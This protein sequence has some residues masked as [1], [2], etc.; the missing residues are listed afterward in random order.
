MSRATRGLGLLL[1]AAAWTLPGCRNGSLARSDR[2]SEPVPPLDS[3]ARAF[4]ASREPGVLGTVE[5]IP[6]EGWT[7]PGGDSFEVA[8]RTTEAE[9]GPARQFGQIDLSIALRNRSAALT[10]YPCTSCHQG[11]KLLMQARRITDAHQNIQPVHPS[12][13]GALC[14]TCHAPED[15]GTLVLLSGKRVSLDESYQLCAQCHIPQATAWAKGAHGKRLDGW[16]GRRVVM[17]C[18]DC[19]DPHRPALQQRIPFRAPRIARTPTRDQP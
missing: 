2:A 11:R 4:N 8:R 12:R 16:Q 13:T 17:P 3:A 1:L 18:P 15:V 6:V 19:H 9:T 5:A 7:G 10:Q 14:S